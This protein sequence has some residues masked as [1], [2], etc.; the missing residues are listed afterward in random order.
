M[1]KYGKSH[2]ISEAIM[3]SEKL[4]YGCPWPW[5]PI[6]KSENWRGNPYLEKLIG[7]CELLPYRL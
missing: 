6:V 3:K 2:C 4:F 5:D 7:V 1:P